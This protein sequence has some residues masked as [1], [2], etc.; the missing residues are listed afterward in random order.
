MCNWSRKDKAVNGKNN[1]S[2]TGSQTVKWAAG[3]TTVEKK[4]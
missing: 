2:R 4:L 1:D 3:R